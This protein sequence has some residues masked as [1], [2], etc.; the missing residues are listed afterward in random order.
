[1]EDVKGMYFEELEKVE[2]LDAAGCGAAFGVG[3][4]VGVVIYVGLA[5]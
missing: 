2:E 3:F 5:T 1:M 4:F